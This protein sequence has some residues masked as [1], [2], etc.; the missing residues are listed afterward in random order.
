[1]TR[2]DGQAVVASFRHDGKASPGISV[3]LHLPSG[4][5]EDRV[6]DERGEIR[7]DAAAAGLYGLRARWME[8]RKG[9]HERKAFG[10]VRYYSTLTFHV[11]NGA[12]AVAGGYPK[13]SAPAPAEA[14]KAKAD[15]AA[16]ALLEAAHNNR[17]VMPPGFAG[18]RSRLLYQRD[19]KTIEGTL[20]YRR[21][22]ETEVAID[23]LDAESQAWVKRQILNLVG[24]RRGGDF[25]Q[26]DGR[27]PLQLGPD[28]GNAYGRLVLV[29]DDTQSSYR[30]RD[31]RVMEVTR[32]MEGSCFTISVIE[33]ME[34]DAG[35]YLANHFVVSYR[36]PK[37]GELQKIEGYRDSYSRVAGVWLPTSRTVL[38]IGR[39]ASPQVRMIRFRNI[40]HLE[41]PPQA[42]SAGS[43]E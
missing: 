30:I 38:D 32:T 3:R 40:E 25:A 2:K 36:D 12:S 29:N 7:F 18:F 24:H 13:S 10:E 41:P 11:T 6:S 26:G 1:V 19:G 5:T 17:Q 35:R 4:Q 39:D 16:Y 22:G 37:S 15:P 8:D 43:S 31:N 14:T 28:D 21:Q 34:A 20:V 33:T 27:Y 9:T 23:G 42:A